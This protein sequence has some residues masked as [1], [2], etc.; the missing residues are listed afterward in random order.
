MSEEFKLYKTSK[1]LLQFMTRGGKVISFTKGRLR[2]TDKEAIKLLDGM[3]EA[4]EKVFHLA[5]DQNEPEPMK[6]GSN[7]ELRR[8]Q[9]R[10]FLASQRAEVHIAQVPAQPLKATST[11][12]SPITGGV[13]PAAPQFTQAETISAI[14]GKLGT[15]PVVGNAAELLKAKMAMEGT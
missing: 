13:N 4:G 6:P 8:Q 10:E 14:K 9:I 5:A 12:D 11:A 3:L 7:V 15:V 2:T 1:P